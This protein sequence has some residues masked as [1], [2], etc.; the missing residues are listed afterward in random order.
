MDAEAGLRRR[1]GR[2]FRAAIWLDR[3]GIDRLDSLRGPGGSFSD[4]IVR[5]ASEKG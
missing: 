5:P 4:V 3:A 1:P 2:Q